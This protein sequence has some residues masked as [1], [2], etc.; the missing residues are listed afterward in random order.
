MTRIAHLSD[1]HVLEDHHQSRAAKERLRLRYLSFG[2]PLD[3]AGRRERLRASL[4]RV[5]DEAV[6]HLV[7]TGDLTEDG[8]D[9]QFEALAEVLTEEVR[10]PEKVTL[11][12]GNHDAYTDVHAFDRALEGPLEPFAR[13]SR[14]GQVV[15]FDGVAFLPLSTTIDQAFTRSGGIVGTEDLAALDALAGDPVM[16]RRALVVAQHH[17][18]T[19]HPVPGMGFIDGLQNHRQERALLDRHPHLHVLHGHTH[20]ASDRAVGAVP[21]P[22]VFC[23]TAVV[24]HARPLRLYDCEGGRLR[25]VP[26]GDG[27]AVTRRL[28]PGASHPV[29]VAGL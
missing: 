21:E 19:S 27:E 25:P 15:L 23:T 8:T 17:P 22:R 18:P 20:R 10:D 4:E 29:A 26:E 5:R 6:D 2:R 24:E 11:V 12:P 14:P 1:L 7:V 28:F 3:A 16:R 13:T 9:A